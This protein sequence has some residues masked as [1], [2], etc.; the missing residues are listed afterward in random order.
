[1]SKIQAAILFGGANSEHQVSLMSAS[2]VLRNIPRDLYDV[3]MIGITRDGHWME[4]TGPI[5]LIEK[6][7]W[8]TSGCTTPAFISRS[9]ERRVGKECRSR[10]SPYH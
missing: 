10:W 2:S 5:D 7:Q 9:E 8:E 6:D 3:T 4:Y 1:M